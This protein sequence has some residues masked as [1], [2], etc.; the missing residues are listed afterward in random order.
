MVIQR[1]AEAARHARASATLLRVGVLLVADVLALSIG[2]AIVDLVIAATGASPRFTTFFAQLLPQNNVA[3]LEVLCAVTLGLALLRNYGPGP[4]RQNTGRLFAGLS[5]GLTF[6]VWSSFWDGISP[7]GVFGFLVAVMFLGTLLVADRAAV[8]YF[9]NAVRPTAG[10]NSRAIVVGSRE[11]ATEVMARDH[12]GASSRFLVVGFVGPHT[13]SLPDSLGGID[14]LVWILER[15]AIDTV[16]ITEGLDDVSLLEVL[17][18]CDRTGC[19]A[20]SVSPHFPVGGFIPRVVSRGPTPY[21]EL[22]RPSLR[23]PQL[24]IKRAF[25]IVFATLLLI[26]LSP[27]LALVALAVRATSRGRVIFAQDRVGYA[28]RIFTMYKFRT[29]V[30]DA[31]KARDS[32]NGDSL[33]EDARVFKIRNDPRVTRLG[34]ILRR[35]SLDE[36]PQL[37][38]VLWG[39]MSLVGP[40]PPLAKEVAQYEDEHYTRFDMKPGITGPWQVAGRNEVTRF[41]EI[42]ALDAAYLTDWTIAKDFM[43][44]LRTIPAVITMRGAM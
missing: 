42:L 33:Y 9:V 7:L 34:K 37:W 44:L 18:V 17:D 41:E 35:T 13:G 16:M 38:N 1:R 23:A 29:M 20:L 3:S 30:E 14:D 6:V 21:V 32:L 39:E 27:L 10:V 43:I 31:E 36:L 4:Q 2:L 28:G 11:H 25:D 15:Y 12:L 26:V 40:R 24:A 19:T 5:L 22:I 8:D